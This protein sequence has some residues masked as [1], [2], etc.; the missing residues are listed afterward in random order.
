MITITALR[1]QK[2]YLDKT[3]AANNP[4]STLKTVAQ[5]L[6]TID[7]FNAKIASGACNAAQNFPGPL[8]VPNMKIDASGSSMSGSIM[9]T[10]AVMLMGF[11][12]S[13]PRVCLMPERFALIYFLFC[14]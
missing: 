9:P 12:R 6:V 7:S 1:P 3:Y 2:L 11:I 13:K 8:L 14:T 10:I 4:N 5:K